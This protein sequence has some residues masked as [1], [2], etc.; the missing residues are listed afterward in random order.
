V[1]V[2]FFD[3]GGDVIGVCSQCECNV[4]AMQLLQLLTYTHMLHVGSQFVD[5]LKS[6]KCRRHYDYLVIRRSMV[7][8][9]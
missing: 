6:S 7:T 5:L 1:D 4:N 8:R 9:A 3:K 2:Y